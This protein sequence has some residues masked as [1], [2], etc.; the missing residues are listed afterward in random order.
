MSIDLIVREKLQTLLNQA[1]SITDEQSAVK[2]CQA[3]LDDFEDFCGKNYEKFCEYTDS[4]IIS[5]VSKGEHF[6]VL[7]LIKSEN[8]ELIRNLKL[9]LKLLMRIN[10]YA[11][12]ETLYYKEQEDWL[13]ELEKLKGIE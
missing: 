8:H 4:M 6:E 2:F 11:D 5:N 12:P 1:S 9:A 10:K 13:N 3:N 7:E